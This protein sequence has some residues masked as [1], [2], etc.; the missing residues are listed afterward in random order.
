MLP[1]LCTSVE[2]KFSC[3]YK[4]E[5]VSTWAYA[6]VQGSTEKLLPYN[7]AYD[8]GRVIVLH[9]RLTQLGKH[10]RQMLVIV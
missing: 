9:E 10:R 4:G 8:C 1:A 7:I 2:M 3:I 6:I 5:F